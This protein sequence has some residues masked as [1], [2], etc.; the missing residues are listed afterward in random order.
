MKYVEYS[1][2]D[3][4]NYYRRLYRNKEVE[5]EGY[6]LAYAF[7]REVVMK[8]EVLAEVFNSFLN[9]RVKEFSS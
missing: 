3:K 8:D 6:K 1:D 5:I 7:I 9:G 4:V 2:R